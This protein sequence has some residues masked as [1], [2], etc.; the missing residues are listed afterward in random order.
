MI[1][2]R[3]QYLTLGWEIER[4]LQVFSGAKGANSMGHPS[5]VSKLRSRLELIPYL[6]IQETVK[7]DSR[8]INATVYNT[9]M[10]L[11]TC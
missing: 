4:E 7:V 9:P 6:V 11:T 3:F 5:V 10:H 1:F 2:A 8:S